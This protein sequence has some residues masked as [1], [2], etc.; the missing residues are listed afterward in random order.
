MLPGT[1]GSR[2]GEWGMEGCGVRHAVSPATM[3][4]SELQDDCKVI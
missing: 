3:S 1:A 2:A 4:Q